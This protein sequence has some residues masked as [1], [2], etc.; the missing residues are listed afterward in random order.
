MSFGDLAPDLYL[1]VMKSLT[2]ADD[3]DH[4]EKREA[5]L[6]LLAC[7]RTCRALRTAASDESVWHCVSLMATTDDLDLHAE[8]PAGEAINHGAKKSKQCEG[9]H[10]GK[11]DARVAYCPSR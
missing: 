4:Y 5:I 8:T 9:E 11:G 7:K 3:D 1:R 10:D 2:V 6:D